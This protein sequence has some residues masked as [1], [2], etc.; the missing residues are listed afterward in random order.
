MSNIPQTFPFWDN[1][2]GS[3]PA[4]L[5]E[6]SRVLRLGRWSVGTAM[7]YLQLLDITEIQH[8]NGLSRSVFFMLHNV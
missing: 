8:L 6:Q 4:N 1:L 2:L 7:A 5:L 3:D